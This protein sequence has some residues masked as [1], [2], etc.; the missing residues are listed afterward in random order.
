MLLK[1]KTMRKLFIIAGIIVI[2]AA[3]VSCGGAEG[4]D[5]GQTY[6]P[7]MAYS[8]AYETYGYNSLPEDHD[9]KS[10]RAY[11]NGNPVAGTMAR[12]D[13]YTF[14]IAGGDSGYLQAKTYQSPDAGNA[15]Y[16]CTEKRSR[17]FIPDQLWY[18]PRHST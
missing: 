15:V 16:T 13:S 12:G 10:R 3:L 8:R 6:M 1:L 17:A 5:P 11:Y 7:D 18:L 14:P 4:E 2:S 9:L